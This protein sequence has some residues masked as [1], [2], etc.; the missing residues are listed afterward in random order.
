[1][2]FPRV[3][4]VSQTLTPDLQE[5]DMLRFACLNCPFLFS[6]VY[7]HQE[8]LTLIFILFGF[9]KIPTCSEFMCLL[10]HI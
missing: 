2:S 3:A 8:K 6:L 9:M 1:M 10:L 4:A 7:I 5:I